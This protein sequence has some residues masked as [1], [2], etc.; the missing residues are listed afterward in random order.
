MQDSQIWPAESPSDEVPRY[1]YRFDSVEY[2]ESALELRVDGALLDV[3]PRP[4]Q[5]LTHLLKY[6]NEVVTKEELLQAGWDGRPAV[7]NVLANAISKLRRALG[8]QA[9]SRIVNVP[10]I[11]YRFTGTVERAVVG[12]PPPTALALSAGMPVQGR[13][14]FHLVRSL[15][16]NDRAHVWLAR[17]RSTGQDRVFKFA[18]D[19]NSLRNL[20]RESTLTRVLQQTFPESAA[21][22]PVCGTNFSTA[23]YFMERDFVGPDLLQWAEHDGRLATLPLEE[24]LELFGAIARAV[25]AAHSVGILHRDLKPSNVLVRLVGGVWRPA[26]TD[27]GSAR[28]LDEAHVH[29][30]GVTLMGLTVVDDGASPLLGSTLMYAA[31][32]LIAG[33]GATMQSDVYSLGVM[34]YQMVV[35]DLRRPLGTGWQREVGDEL[36]AD[37]ITAAT[38][39]DASR[40]LLDV[41]QLLERLTQ[42][43]QRRAQGRHLAELDAQSKAAMAE[44][45]RRRARRPW[46]VALVAVLSVMVIGA[47]V[48]AS[49]IQKARDNEAQE[50]ARAERVTDFLYRDVLHAPDLVTGNRAKP[51]QMIDVLRRAATLA[52]QRF[53]GDAFGEALVHRQLAET[54]TRMANLADARFEIEISRKM[55]EAIVPVGHPELLK[56]QFLRVWL[57]AWGLDFGNAL[58]A[59]A[60]AEQAA[61]EKALLQDTELAYFATR[62]RLELLMQQQQF[63]QCLPVAVRMLQLAER[64][65]P[66]D[67]GLQLDARVRIAEIHLELDQADR[68][69]Q[70]FSDVAKPPFSAKDARGKALA[71]RHAKSFEVALRGGDVRL[72][73]QFAQQA[74]DVLLADA[75]PNDFYLAFAHHSLA[76][77]RSAQGEFEKAQV[78]MQRALPFMVR[79]VGEDHFYVPNFQRELAWAELNL[80]RPA[81]ALQLFEKVAQWSLTH[82][83]NRTVGPSTELG[84]ARALVELGR[85]AEAVPVL[86]ALTTKRFVDLGLPQAA[87][88]IRLATERANAHLALGNRAEAQL[89]LAALPAATADKSPVWPWEQRRLERVQ[90]RVQ[91]AQRLPAPERPGSSPTALRTR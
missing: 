20:K 87:S 9:G 80:G 72:A 67:L 46:V 70:I 51:V 50:R 12:V 91:E 39:A 60:Q 34:L 24:R 18:H 53:K 11:G 27:F 25:A 28:V 57:L 13:A 78:E 62:A 52:P 55:F 66:G 4:L 47:V 16:Y 84:R 49:N 10:R 61:G 45:Q 14:G 5:V 63:A 48:Q 36:L 15:A 17:H 76:A 7:E 71:R 22:V 83:S 68:A 73:E 56:T 43:E 64:L 31:P 65:F 79:A 29:A 59:L 23:P 35:G 42:L 3:E 86:A 26:V 8:A 81:V 77:V 37:D 33:K 2:D 32:E 89:A 30:A 38:E 1:R 54:H 40:R 75:Q 41:G 19:A 21:F 90:A 6:A 74:L 44:L 88:E 58:P 69:E 82:S 85:G